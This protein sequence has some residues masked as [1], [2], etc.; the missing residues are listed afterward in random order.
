MIYLRA[1]KSDVWMDVVTEQRD[2]L[3]SDVISDLS[4]QQHELSVWEVEDNLSNLDDIILAI[5]LTRNEVK[6]LTLVKLSPTH[7][8]ES[9][10]FKT[11]ITI[12]I[13]PGNTGYLKM[14]NSHK[15]F[16]LSSFWEIGFL[17]EY[18]ANIITTDFFGNCLLF[19]IQDILKILANR[20][21]A[22]DIDRNLL[23]SSNG[24]WLKA[25]K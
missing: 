22:G 16:M 23:K 8:K 5:A 15:N 21:D 10:K 24:K 14:A 9:S 3:D 7:M 17:A 11:D 4:T 13:Q 20:L 18:I 19:N 12:E 25:L 6:D 2:A 1:L